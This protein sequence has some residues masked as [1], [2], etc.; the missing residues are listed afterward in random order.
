VT[1]EATGSLAPFP[2]SFL[3]KGSFHGLCGT[4]AVLNLTHDDFHI[5]GSDGHTRYARIY[6]RGHHVLLEAMTAEG[7]PPTIIPFRAVVY[8]LNTGQNLSFN[9]GH[10]SGQRAILGRKP[11]RN[12]ELERVEITPELRAGFALA[13]QEPATTSPVG[14]DLDLSAARGLASSLNGAAAA[15]RRP[16]IG[17]RSS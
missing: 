8:V 4:S 10:A 17:V 12:T 14:G 15:D 9:A 7:R 13:G 6:A 3:P 2:L 5:K 1:N 16:A 11:T